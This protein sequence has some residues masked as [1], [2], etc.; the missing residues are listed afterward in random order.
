VLDIQ[1]NSIEDENILSEI[2]EK[3]PNL[4]VLY[5]QNNPFVLPFFYMRNALIFSAKRF[6]VIEK[7]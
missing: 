3:M 5:T 7:Q 2:F 4:A 1:D 6:Q